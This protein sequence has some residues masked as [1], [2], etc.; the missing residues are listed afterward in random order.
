MNGP[1]DLYVGFDSREEI[2]YH[3]FFSSVLHH[4]TTPV[5]ITTLGSEPLRNVWRWGSQ[6]GSNSFTYSRFLVPYLNE[7][8]NWAIFCDGSDMLVRADMSELW[9]L[10]DYTKAVL[11]VPHE[12]KTRH[13]RKYVG[14]LMEWDNRDYPRKNWSS[15]MLINCAHHVWR[16]LLP[17]VVA[18]LDGSFLHGFE[19]MQDKH[20][21]HLPFEWNHLVD[22][23]GAN[24]AAKILHWTAGIPAWPHYSTAPMSDEWARAALQVTH[25]TL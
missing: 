7:F 15:V 17:N 5:R 24:D 19:F 10:R 18:K 25:A 22:E 11:V 16:D 6:D 20:I 14:T 23:Y 4:T 21:G 3:T 1:I 2:G 13:P 12:Y 8:K 9:M